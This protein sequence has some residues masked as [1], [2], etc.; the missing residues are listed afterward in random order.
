MD[1]ASIIVAVVGG[2]G[3]TGLTVKLY[4]LLQEHKR[5]ELDRE[6][7]AIKRWQTLANEADDDAKEL[8]AELTW[9]RSSYAKLWTTWRIG[10]PPGEGDFP[11]Y[12]PGNNKH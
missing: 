1:W 4:T 12:Y 7:T 10:P 2:G 6:D 5:G 3:A 9:Y 11:P 8:R